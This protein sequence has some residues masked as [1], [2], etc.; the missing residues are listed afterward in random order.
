M[1][2][3]AVGTL[4]GALARCR[5]RHRGLDQLRHEQAGFC[6]EPEKF[7]TGHIEGIVESGASNNAAVSGTL[8]PALVFGIPGDTITA[9]MIGVLYLKDLNPGPMIFQNQPELVTAIFIVFFVSNII[10]VPFGWLA[11]KSS[12]HMVRVPRAILMPR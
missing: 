9:M 11:I 5:L 4:I 10:M 3:S 6:K 12:V 1:R 8:I 7:G 2:G